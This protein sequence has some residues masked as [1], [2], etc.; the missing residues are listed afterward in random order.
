V[1]HDAG[2]L[3]G[4]DLSAS[5]RG[6]QGIA[7]MQALVQPITWADF[8]EECESLVQGF[9]VRTAKQWCWKETDR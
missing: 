5:T 4:F 1:L 6:V 3:L 7:Y 8:P 2:S 9:A